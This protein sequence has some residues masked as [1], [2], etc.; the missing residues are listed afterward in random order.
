MPRRAGKSEGGG[1]RKGGAG[2]GSHE[3]VKAKF[4]GPVPQIRLS[5]R[6]ALQPNRKGYVTAC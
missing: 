1:E 2:G 5:A 4:K 6:Q 3:P